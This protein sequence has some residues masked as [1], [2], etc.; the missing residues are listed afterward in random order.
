[1]TAPTTDE[2]KASDGEGAPKEAT[3]DAELLAEGKERYK[4]CAEGWADNRKDWLDDALFRVPGK[5]NQ[6]PEEVRKIREKAGR[7][8]VEVDKLNQYVRQV[9][10]DGR[11]NR[12]G[13]KVRPEG[14]GAAKDVAEKFDDL[15]R[16]ICARSNADEAFDTSLDH[17]AGNGYGF[18]RVT[19]DYAHPGTFNQDIFVK[20]V[21]NPRSV[22][23]DPFIQAA[24]GSDA[25][26]GFVE[27]DEPKDEFKRKWPKAKFTDWTGDKDRYGSDWLSE[28]S[29]KV[30]EYWYKVETPTTVHLL[31]D[32]TTSTDEEYQAAVAQLSPGSVA[33]QIVDTREL[34]ETEVRW[35]RMSGAEILEKK[36]WLGKYIPLIL[37]IGNESDIDGKVSYSGMIRPAKDAMRLYNYSRSAYAERV[38]LTPKAP[39]VAAAGQVEGHPEW[40]DANTGNY[41]VLVYDPI[42]VNGTPLPPPQRQSPSDIPAG[43]AQDMQLSEHDIQGSIGMYN[44]NLGEKSNEKSGRAITARQREGDVGTF[45][46]PDNLN[47]SIR[48]LG[49]ILVDLVPKI[50]DSRRVAHLLAEDGTPSTITIDPE[51][52][53]PSQ[54][55]AGETI[56]NFNIGV[57]GV[58]VS[59][60]P[61]YTTKRQESVEAQ[62]QMVQSAP[63][64]MQ[65]AGDLIVRNMDWP[66]AD[67]LAERFKMML[68]PPV[69]QALAAEEQ[70]QDPKVMAAVA[71]LQQQIQQNQQQI[72]AAESGIQERDQALQKLQMENDALKSDRELNAQKIQ[73]ERE[74]ASNE[75]L[76]L[77]NEARTAGVDPLAAEQMRLEHE[78]QWK[79]LD[80]DTKVIVAAF[81]AKQAVDTATV[82]ANGSVAAAAHTANAAAA[83]A[84]A[85]EPQVETPQVDTNAALQAALAG[86]TEAVQT[87]RQPRTATMSD[88]RQ[89][90]IE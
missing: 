52:E 21:R 33:P 26:F 80:A 7:P 76:K 50:L 8:C 84:Q 35:C 79:K 42:D 71:P 83:E 44:A 18:F 20:R 10:N 66:G 32:S 39:F 58:D 47:R 49:R 54:D 27:T 25:R 22:L 5:G 64:I 3:T 63:E 51:M 72:Q 15:I 17:A 4:L 1:M 86:F 43:F 53:K 41:S 65:F 6:W 82:T 19:T 90:R 62:M 59:S 29:V 75:R 78:D 60:G 68:P 70:G 24:D 30:C 13:V 40:E 89:V 34:P 23:L 38:A 9:V 28:K 77:E 85:V 16:G 88:G 69:Q 31:S 73:L 2:N 61:S 74:K 57:Y 45:H 14:D 12:P 36:K 56:Y 81:N 48:Y 87:L 11:Q 37:V 55:M 67:A 46:Y